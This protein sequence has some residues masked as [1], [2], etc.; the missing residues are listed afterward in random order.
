MDTRSACALPTVGDEKEMGAACPVV[1][2]LW[3]TRVAF[4]YEGFGVGGE[5]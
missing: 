5:Q 4:G 2:R 3:G 1:R